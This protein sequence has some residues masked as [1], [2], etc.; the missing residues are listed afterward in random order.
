MSGEKEV[1]LSVSGIAKAFDSGSSETNW[2]L[3]GISF[4]AYRGD[5]IGV[6]GKNGSGK[7]TL[8]KILSGITKPTKGR[9]EIRGRVASVLDVGAGFHPDLSG[10]ENVYLRG[11]LL[12]MTRSEI[13]AVFD[14][15]VDFSNIGRFIDTAVKHYS[16]GMFLRLA[17]S[18][19]IHLDFDVLLLDEVL[20]VG[21]VQFRKKTEGKILELAG[22]KDKT[23]LI[24]SHNLGELANLA[25]R[26]IVIEDGNIKADG[27]GFEVIRDYVSDGDDQLAIQGKFE[28]PFP[29]KYGSFE[30]TK[31]ML[32][33]ANGEERNSFLYNEGFYIELDLSTRN[34][35]EVFPFLIQ[36][37]DTFNNVVLSISYLTD[38][39]DFKL[40]KTG[41]SY[42]FKATFPDSLFNFGRYY[43]SIFSIDEAHRISPI[44]KKVTH[45]D[46]VRSADEKSTWFDDSP[47]PFR[48]PLNWTCEEATEQ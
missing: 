27:H 47:A 20:Q 3:N 35:D 1:V 33:A 30:L 18:V 6:V 5:I 44:K 28:N 26:F 9:V 16:D 37:S 36:V 11:E 15:I 29:L 7:S 17:F 38:H 45:F 42:R 22:T 39:P 10:R 2:A 32:R 23:L 41:V 14:Q 4:E 43:V 19:I 25:N 48:P 40:E 8:L 31:I 13:D 21:D 24:V 46:V 12:G 34:T